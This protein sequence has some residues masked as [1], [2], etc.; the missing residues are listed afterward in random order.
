MAVHFTNTYVCTFFSSKPVTVFKL[1]TLVQVNA[2]LQ[3]LNI[4]SE[5]LR[6]HHR[7]YIDNLTCRE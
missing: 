4:Q 3:H 2:D 7:S 6:N 1:H 5:D